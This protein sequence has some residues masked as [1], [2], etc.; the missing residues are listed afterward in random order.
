MRDLLEPTL[1]LGISTGTFTVYKDYYW[2]CSLD[3][4][5]VWFYGKGWSAPQCNVNK[6]ITTRISHSH[7]DMYPE[8]EQVVKKYH[9]LFVPH[10]CIV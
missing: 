2:V 9:I 10:N 4:Q 7:S 3:L 6:I 1:K 5:Y 8:P